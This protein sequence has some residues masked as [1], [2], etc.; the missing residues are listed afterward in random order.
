ML[1]NSPDNV[2][3]TRDTRYS[4]MLFIEFSRGTVDIAVSLPDFYMN[5]EG[6]FC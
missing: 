2:P 4:T 6:P 5:N 3:S 1:V